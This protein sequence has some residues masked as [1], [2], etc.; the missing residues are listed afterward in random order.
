MNQILIYVVIQTWIKLRRNKIDFIL[1]CIWPHMQNPHASL[2]S[3]P[4]KKPCTQDSLTVRA[5]TIVLRCTSCLELLI[6]NN[7]RV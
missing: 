5:T 6:S 1:N 7:S 2:L 3:C 4:P